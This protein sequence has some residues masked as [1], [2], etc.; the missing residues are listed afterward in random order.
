MFGG[1]NYLLKITK[2]EQSKI[3]VY[4]SGILLGSI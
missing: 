2:Q 1:E 3:M 4:Y